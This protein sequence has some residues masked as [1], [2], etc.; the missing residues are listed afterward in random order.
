MM[1][2]LRAQV[3]TFGVAM[4]AGVALAHAGLVVPDARPWTRRVLEG[5]SGALL[6]LTWFVLGNAFLNLH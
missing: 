4:L 3:V 1:P 6:L 2:H 5:A